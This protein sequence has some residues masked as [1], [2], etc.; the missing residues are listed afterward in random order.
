MSFTRRTVLSVFKVVAGFQPAV[1]L[2]ILP[3]GLSCGLRGQFRAQNC[4]SGRQDAALY[5]SQDGW[6]LVSGSGCRAATTPSRLRGADAT[7]DLA[8]VS[9]MN[10]SAGS[11]DS[12]ATTAQARTAAEPLARAARLA[13][14]FCAAGCG[15][16]RRSVCVYRGASARLPHRVFG[17]FAAAERAGG[18]HVERLKSTDPKVPIGTTE[19]SPRFQPQKCAAGAGI[20]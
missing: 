2:G 16:T 3:S 20:L 1:E 12:V 14:S 18:P 19:N 4:H 13:G 10:R 5:G 9:S 15:A 17:A 8:D 11:S 7:S 6:Y